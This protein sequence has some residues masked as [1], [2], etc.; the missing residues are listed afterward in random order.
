MKKELSS[1]TILRRWELSGLIGALIIVLIIPAYLFKEKYRISKSQPDP[2]AYYDETFV[3]REKCV[4]C[5]KKE[6]DK[7]QGSHHDKA[8]DKA[9]DETVL[10]D[11]NNAVFVH[12]DVETRF[13]RQDNKFMVRTQGSDGVTADF[14]VKYTF[15]YTPLQ[16][17]LIPF[18]G[19]RLQCLTIAWDT[20]KKQWYHLYPDEPN[21]PNDW[22]HWT[23]NA[24][25]WNGM[26]AECHS[27][28]LH[29]NYEIET[30][31][32]NTTWSE[33]DVSCE[34]CHGPGS[35]HVSWAEVP[36]MAR[37]K[38]I[39]NVG[40]VVRTQDISARQQVELCSRCHAR[41]ASLGDYSH[42]N[43]DIM[44]YMVPQSL[45]EGLY[46]ADGQI[47]EEVYVYGSFVQ[48]K[49]YAR[50][51]RCSDCHDVHSLKLHKKGND[52]C[53]QCH[54]ADHYDTRDHHFH[55]KR[56]EKGD[57]VKAQDGSILYAV[58]TGAECIA[59]HMPGRYYMG[60]DFRN[61]H[62][63]RIP[64][65]DL[66]MAL[67]TPNACN[68]CHADKTF[69]WSVDH[70]TQW[71]GIKKK[72]HYGNVF[73]AARRGRPEVQTDLIRLVDDQLS[74][75]IVRS[76]ALSLLRSYDTNESRAVFE[77]ALMDPEAMV[78][79][80]ALFNMVPLTARDQI[81]LIVP[82]LYDPVKAVRIQA[83]MSL[84]NIPPEQIRPRERQVFKAALSEYVKS[85]EHV[86]DFSQGRFNLGNL[87]T[88]QG[89]TDLA[90]AHYKAAIE[91]DTLFYPAK[92]NLAMLYNQEGRNDDA[93]RLLREVVEENPNLHEAAYSLG[94]L[95]AEQK[96]Y[97]DAARYLK[98]AADGMPKRARVHYNLGLILQQ[99][100][101]QEE[102]EVALLHTLE[103]DPDA[104]DY[105]H[106]V[107][108]HYLRVRDFQKARSFAQQMTEKH[109]DNDLGEK[110]LQ[111]I[112]VLMKEAGK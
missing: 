5:H 61:D 86:G 91:I 84:T 100:G 90:E 51:V 37:S 80:T 99:L 93:E 24:Q 46:F 34:G 64:R 102:A 55:K 72:P 76:T 28:R 49:M 19:G 2:Q 82:L 25:N 50:D 74:P 13:F 17:Y 106:A 35:R 95:L 97:R 75:G 88:N 26:C 31:S 54:R 59:C 22:L 32:Y 44:D 15:G 42:A 96:N 47:L 10:G 8:M 20:E 112:A 89:K 33:I 29:K 14:E 81:R 7:W 23:R 111:I 27:T 53:L 39:E 16:Q 56:G 109:P 58:G 69:K 73:A 57:P 110:I 3:G 43:Q 45:S 70:C 71:Y 77:R 104:I 4:D 52:V 108:D 68:T 18:A 21:D 65:P 94:L 107:A 6:H 63:L 48:S 62:S 40:L 38:D 36:V 101:M 87:F 79:H 12:K 11:F 85:M 41:R 83:A 1:E 67:G 105:L 66:S 103:I 30:D 92:V 9:T 60:I 98:K 78:R